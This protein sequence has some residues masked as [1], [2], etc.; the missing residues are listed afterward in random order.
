M[1]ELAI[2]AEGLSKRYLIGQ[3]QER[4]RASLRETIADSIK[5]P[6]Q[7]AGRLVRGE[8]VFDAE[9]EEEKAFEEQNHGTPEVFKRDYYGN[10]VLAITLDYLRL[11]GKDKVANARA[12]LPPN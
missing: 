2:R 1:S 5:R 3:R 6:L 11:L 10:E 12:Q 9:K 4:F 7:R 8:S